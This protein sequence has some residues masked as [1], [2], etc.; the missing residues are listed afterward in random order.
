MWVRFQLSENEF[1]AFQRLDARHLP[2]ELLLNDGRVH[3]APGEIENTLNGVNTRTGTLEV[4]ARFANPDHSLLPGQ[5]G[6]VRIRL[7]ER[8][9]ADPG[10]AE[11]RA[12]APGPADGADRRRQG[13]RAG[14]HRSSRATASATAGW[15]R[16]GS[17]PATR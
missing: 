1:L 10:A 2:I 16:R 5:F 6:R 14:A 13:R 8:A 4:Q 3:P 12:G 9:D 11:G 7:A 15:W 17:P